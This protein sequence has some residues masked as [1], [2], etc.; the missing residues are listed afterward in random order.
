MSR[1][2]LAIL[3][4]SSSG[5]FSATLAL[6]RGNTSPGQ[7]EDSSGNGRTLTMVGTVPWSTVS[8]PEGD[9]WLGS[10]F[11]T[12]NYFSVPTTAV[13]ATGNRGSICFYYLH[14]TQ[15]ATAEQ[16]NVINLG[17]TKYIVL[18]V[19]ATDLASWDYLQLGGGNNNQNAG[20]ITYAQGVTYICR[21]EWDNGTSF[22]GVRY[23]V[24]GAT[25]LTSGVQ[26][27]YGTVFAINI[28]E[29]AA[30]NRP[31]NG[32]IDLMQFSDDPNAEFPPAAQSTSPLSPYLKNSNRLNLD[33]PRFLRLFFCMPSMA[34]A[35]PANN[36]VEAVKNNRD[37]FLAQ[38]RNQ[39]EKLRLDV[40]AGRVTVTRTPTTV[41]TPR[42][43]PTLT[44]RP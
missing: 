19:L 11:A 12:T 41:P 5:A 31:I 35:M 29:R 32:K 20:S 36:G 24:N 17:T 10:A 28:G 38:S 3:L 37:F 9:H 39:A 14:E 23:K 40:L 22:T 27:D 26:V 1:L 6:Y 30:A 2:L 21:L 8:P 42:V 7:L 16:V 15:L 33:P 44:P 34:N 25:I 18:K 13:P 43:T 4:A